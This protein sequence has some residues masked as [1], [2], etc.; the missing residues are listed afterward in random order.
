MGALFSKRGSPEADY[1]QM[2]LRAQMKIDQR[3]PLWWKDQ[4]N[5]STG[6][7]EDFSLESGL[8]SKPT[9][10]HD[11]VT[12]T[13]SSMPEL[14]EPTPTECSGQT[15]RES[16]GLDLLT[17]EQNVNRR[18]IEHTTYIIYM[19]ERPRRSPLIEHEHFCFFFF[20]LRTMFSC[21]LWFRMNG[22]PWPFAFDSCHLLTVTNKST[23]GILLLYKVNIF[24]SSL[25][26]SVPGSNILKS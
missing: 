1:E 10:K 23:P 21:Y 5:L 20:I 16:R 12:R 22:Q 2:L 7:Y 9:S 6:G 19:W 11:Q 14:M 26:Y 3:R 25:S 15:E 4:K 17:P 24:V 18:G 13:L 8:G